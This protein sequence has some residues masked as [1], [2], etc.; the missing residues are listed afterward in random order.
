MLGKIVRTTRE[1]MVGQMRLTWWYEA[2]LK[3]DK[4]APPAEPVL[5]ALYATVVPAGVSGPEL[6][7]M[8]DGWD[9]LLDPPLDAVALE[10]FAAERGERL[11]AAAAHLLAVE[12]RRI[13]VA[14]RGWALA[15]LSLRL[16]DPVSRAAARERA[17]IALEQALT[18]RWPSRSRA[19]GALA[20]SARFDVVPRALPEGS[21]K[22]V[23]RLAWHRLTGY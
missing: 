20:V 7:A 14:G 10:R 11:F 22:R 18:G 9:A 17:A 5:Q 8:I 16:S 1:P 15:D 21:P 23:A 13:A 12:D 2:L 4:A 19:L 3:L 6:A